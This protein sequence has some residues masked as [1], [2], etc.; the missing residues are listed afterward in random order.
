VYRGSASG[1][2]TPPAVLAGPSSSDPHLIAGGDF[3][4]DGYADL[5]VDGDI[6]D[7]GATGIPQA[8]SQSHPLYLTNQAGPI[9]AVGDIDGDGY[10]DFVIGG[11]AMEC[12]PFVCGAIFV[13]RG[14]ASGIPM[15]VVTIRDPALF[16]DD[17]FGATVAGAGDIDGDGYDDVVAASPYNNGSTG[18]IAT[19]VGAATGITTTPQVC[20]GPDGMNGT[21]GVSAY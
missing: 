7:G 3:N 5:A 14:S 2:V 17:D 12:G 20:V 4:G 13:F 8:P 18:F 19:F 9:A 15:Q 11:P 16:A 1:F 6:Y 10:D 21:F